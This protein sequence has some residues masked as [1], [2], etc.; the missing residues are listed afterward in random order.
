VPASFPSDALLR[1]GAPL[2]V[3]VANWELMPLPTVLPSETSFD[4][5]TVCVWETG[6][7][8]A[9][10]YDPSIPATKNE[11][12]ALAAASGVDD[13]FIEGRANFTK[14]ASGMKARYGLTGTVIEG[15]AAARDAVLAAAS[16]GPC[17]IGLAGDQLNLTPHHQDHSVGHAIAVFYPPGSET[18]GIQLDPLAPQ[19]YP[20]DPF[21]PV[22]MRA[23]TTAAIIFTGAPKEDLT[24]G[25]KA[26]GQ[27]IGQFTFV[28]P[29]HLISPLNPKVHFPRPDGSTFDVVAVLDLK[30]PD[31]RPVDIEGKSP[32]LNNRDQVYLVDAPSFG[33]AAFALRQDGVFIPAAFVESQPGDDG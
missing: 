19:D 20:G 31:G 9:R 1:S 24:P 10:W 30:T 11:V 16:A 12:I 17:A 7:F 5:Q 21:S 6:L 22:E 2:T 23:F 29:H 14:L 15:A 4:P 33:I 3:K 32:P 27:G 13:P 18:T 26:V 8:I 28:G 25:Y